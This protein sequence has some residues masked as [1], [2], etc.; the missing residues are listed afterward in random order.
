[1][2]RFPENA[3]CNQPVQ[4]DPEHPNPTNPHSNNR[5]TQTNP[6]ISRLSTSPT[7]SNDPRYTNVARGVRETYTIPDI[8]SLCS[9]QTS[10]KS[11]LGR[12]S[13]TVTFRM[14][15]LIEKQLLRARVAAEV[16]QMHKSKSGKLSI[17]MKCSA[18]RGRRN[19]RLTNSPGGQSSV[20]TCNYPN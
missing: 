17:I 5:S 16:T 7:P 3:P 19:F 6:A 15:L 20:S 8:H 12:L 11:A 9:I 14:D 2:R 10:S 13:S 18:K 1:M 4:S